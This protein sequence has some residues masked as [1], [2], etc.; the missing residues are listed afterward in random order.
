MI[1]KGAD[2]KIIKFASTKADGEFSL[3]VR[4]TEGC[5]LEV[6]MMGFSRQS[7]ALD[8]IALPVTVGMRPGAT[9][10][11]EVTVLL[12]VMG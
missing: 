11:R 2:R 8:S 4:S 1:V 9:L 12:Y 3:Q 5:R 10:L 7:L 6:S